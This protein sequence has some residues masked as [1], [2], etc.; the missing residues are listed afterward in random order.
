MCVREGEGCRKVREAGQR[1]LRLTAL[2]E[3]GLAGE[4]QGPGIGVG[5]VGP[6]LSQQCVHLLIYFKGETDGEE[7]KEKT[8]ETLSSLLGYVLSAGM[9]HPTPMQWHPV[10]CQPSWEGCSRAWGV[11]Q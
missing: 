2:G 8:G 3:R 6:R 5:C 4:Q 10:V 11:L 9:I 1:G 7:C